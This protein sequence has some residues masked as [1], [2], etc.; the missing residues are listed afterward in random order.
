MSIAQTFPKTPTSSEFENMDNFFVSQDW[1][2]SNLQDPSIRII[3]VGGEKYFN[4]FHIPGA[5]LLSYNNIV[6]KKDGAA[7][8]RADED[9]LI[10]I[11]SQLGIGPQTKVI[12]YDLSGGTDSA[13]FIWSLATL[14]HKG[15]G[16]VLDGGLNCWYEEKRPMV[17]S[18]TTVNR[19]EFISQPD[20]S[21]E[22]SADE[23]D[24]LSQKN[25]DGVIIDVR[26]DK[27]YIGNTMT[28]PRGHIKGALHFEWSQT[29][30]GPRNMRLQDQ[31]QL[32]AML[33]KI[34]VENTEQDIIVYCES[35]HRASQSWLL[36][37]SLGF[38]KVRLFA[39]S[40][41]QWRTLGLPVVH[42]IKPS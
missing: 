20:N 26:T 10:E 35:G 16:M 41:S 33:K 25:W 28:T 31:D 27:E 13:R 39:G 42:G 36:L 7:G 24:E 12:A 5:L 22:I 21:W 11:F 19:V 23:V 1:L 30:R 14:G 32:R 29:L 3:Q 4:S 8:A 15:G 38:K 40:I 34:G 2:E 17:E 9:K 37:R 18:V 6:E